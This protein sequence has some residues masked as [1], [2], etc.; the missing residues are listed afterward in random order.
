MRNSQRAATRYLPYLGF[1]CASALALWS[2]LI[3]G[4]AN[5]ALR[6][7]FTI[8]EKIQ[9]L[10]LAHSQAGRAVAVGTT[11]LLLNDPKLFEQGHEILRSS[12]TRLGEGA[13]PA[14]K[15]LQERMRAV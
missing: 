3:S 14:L 12:L 1:G 8:E 6:S 9:S 4:E 2:L 7:S 5:R 15:D 13:P 11:A 10:F